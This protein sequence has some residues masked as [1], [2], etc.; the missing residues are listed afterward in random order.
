MGVADLYQIL[1]FCNEIYVPIRND[2]I[3]AAKMEQFENLLLPV[4]LP[5]G[6]GQDAENPRSVP[7]G[8]PDGKSLL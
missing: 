4:G 7:H 5:V 1:D 3:S 6:A 2:V 8:K